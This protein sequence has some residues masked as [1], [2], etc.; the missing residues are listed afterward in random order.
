MKK[1]DIAIQAS[2]LLFLGGAV[3]YI[4][5]LVGESSEASKKLQ[6]VYGHWTIAGMFVMLYYL[7][8]RHL[9]ANK[10][11]ASQ[12][13]KLWMLIPLCIYSAGLP[14]VN[15]YNRDALTHGMYYWTIFDYVPY[16]MQSL[17]MAFIPIPILLICMAIQSKRE[18]KSL[19]CYLDIAAALY[20]IIH[21]I[22]S[23]LYIA[24]R[25]TKT[26]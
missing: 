25:L 23:F 3:C 26:E 19:S 15:L 11:R 16:I 4:T 24:L 8:I 20:P 2:V 17:A 7:S 5:F 1:K 22:P 18:E 10:V 13:L 14:I 21:L 12:I 6:L 9:F